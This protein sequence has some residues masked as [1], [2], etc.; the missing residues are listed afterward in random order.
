MTTLELLSYITGLIPVFLSLAGVGALIAI[1]I[2]I[3]KTLNVIK[4]GDAPKWNLGLGTLGLLALIVLGVFKNVTPEQFNTAAGIVATLL[5][6]V[7]GFVTQ[8]KAAAVTHNVLS[9]SELP[10]IGKSRSIED[11]K[12]WYVENKAL[13]EPVID[14]TAFNKP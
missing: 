5:V 1:V 6:T 2:N 10:V 13:R 4:D 9:N 3:L 7:L 12:T 14:A 8:F 11:S